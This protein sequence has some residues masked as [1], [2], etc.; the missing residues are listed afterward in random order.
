MRVLVCGSRGWKDEEAIVWKLDQLL[1]E[2]DDLELISGGAV[3]PDTMAFGWAMDNAVPITVMEPDWQ[4]Y[5][6]R[7]GII[8]ND[9]MLD[10]SPDLVLAFWDGKSKGTKH[11]IDSAHKR[12]ITIE[13][14]L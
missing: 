7:A 10:T 5:G 1:A 6:R 13:V 3:G 4:K 11:T 14:I 12:Q 8:R 2:H 9:Q